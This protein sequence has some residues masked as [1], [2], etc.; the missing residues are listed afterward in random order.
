MKTSNNTFKS[1]ISFIIISFLTISAFGHYGPR[2]LTGGSITTGI[3]YNGFVYLGTK[4]AGVFVST[5]TQLVG[6]RLRAVGLKSGAITAHGLSAFTKESFMKRS[7][8]TTFIVCEGCGTIPIYNERQGLYLCPMCDGPIHYAGESTSS[9]EL[10]PPTKRSKAQF[11]RIEMPYAT[12]LLNKELESYMNISMRYLTEKSLRHLK[13][14]VTGER[15]KVDITLVNA[16]LPVRKIPEF[17]AP[18]VTTIPIPQEQEVLPTESSNK[19]NPENTVPVINA[20]AP[21]QSITENVSGLPHIPSVLESIKP[22]EE[23]LMD[24]GNQPEQPQAQ[25]QAQPQQQGTVMQ[26]VKLV[27]PQQFVQPQT[28]PSLTQELIA[29]TIGQPPATQAPPAQVLMSPSA[30][31]P[32]IMV[33][34]TAPAMIQEGL[35]TMMPQLQAPRQTVKLKRPSTQQ[36]GEDEQAPR[37]YGQPV[38]FLR[39]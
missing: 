21:Q 3:H 34:T 13:K 9:L 31:T 36:G 19:I 17:I 5:N 37:T 1:F 32:V 7:D 20:V 11:T 8:G 27:V 4:D 6:W 15:Q 14:I 2:G 23:I 29:S 16:P 38:Q 33:D 18:S 30:V 25:P 39:L 28:Q 10:I 35:P 22:L 24:Q 12:A 26:E